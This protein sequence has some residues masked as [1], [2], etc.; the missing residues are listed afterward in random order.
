MYTAIVKI[1]DYSIATIYPGNK[2]QSNYGGP[3][4]DPAQF[5]HVEFDETVVGSTL[6][7]N[8]IAQDNAGTTEIVLNT[9]AQRNSK[10]NILRG[11]RAPKL[12]NADINIL[13]HNDSDPNAISTLTAWQTY[14]KDLRTLTDSYKDANNNGTAALD[15]FKEDMS[16]F[17]GWPVEP[18]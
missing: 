5:E 8:L 2:N 4:G 10:L 7:S 15:A 13:L 9:Q 17:T 11:L 12:Q 14:R 6:Q 1:S 16:D 18:V 3:W